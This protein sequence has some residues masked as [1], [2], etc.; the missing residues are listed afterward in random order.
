MSVGSE[1]LPV[2]SGRRE[3]VGWMVLAFLTTFLVTRF[4]THAIRSGTGPFRDASIGG[5]H[6]HHEVYGIFLLLGTG[7]LEFTY[8][9]AGTWGTV[10]AVLFGAGAPPAL[11]EVAVWLR[12]GGGDLD[13]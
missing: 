8:R 7:T 11:R 4:V 12:P 10:L 9:P 2:L 13:P 5:V 1:F 6:L 3:V